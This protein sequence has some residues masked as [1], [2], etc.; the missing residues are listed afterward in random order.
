MW[1][2]VIFRGR[3]ELHKY[4]NSIP[5]EFCGMAVKMFWLVGWRGK[6]FVCEIHEYFPVCGGYAVFSGADVVAEGAVY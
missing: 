5:V 2:R 1:R 6:L 4:W 3:L